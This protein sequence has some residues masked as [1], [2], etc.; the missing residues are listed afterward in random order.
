MPDEFQYDVFLSHS[1]KDKQVVRELAERL[2]NDALKVWSDEWVLKAGDSI[3]TNEGRR[4]RRENQVSLASFT[5]IDS[6]WGAGF[7]WRGGVRRGETRQRYFRKFRFRS[8]KELCLVTAQNRSL[9][10]RQSESNADAFP[11][12]SSFVRM[13][14]SILKNNNLL[15]YITLLF[16]DASSP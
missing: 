7:N 2:R 1:A 8:L 13:I 15:T 9:M 4:C 10:K 12:T 11:S 5:I 3:P 16:R 14:R 6:D